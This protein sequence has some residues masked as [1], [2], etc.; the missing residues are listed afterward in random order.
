MAF[1]DE[2]EC[3]IMADR[4]P[5]TLWLKPADF[6][7]LVAYVAML[8]VFVP[9]H[10]PWEDEAQAWLL[11]RDLSLYSLLFKALRREGHPALWYLILWV[12]TR[13][14]LSYTLFNWLSAAIATL[15][16]Y[17]LLRLS[18]FPFYLRALLPFTFFLGYQYSVVARSYVLFP[19]L[20]FLVAHVYREQPPRPLLMAVLLAL[21][22]NVSVHGTIVA[23]VF[24]ALYVWK[25]KQTGDDP[26]NRF[27]PPR[28]IKLAAAIFTSSILFVAICLWPTEGALP[29]VGPTLN[30]IFDSLSVRKSIAVSPQTAEAT[31]VPQAGPLAV[32]ATSKTASPIPGKA[33]MASVVP[34]LSFAFA[35]SRLLALLYE[36]V[37][38]L[39]LWRSGQMKLAL[40]A[41]ALCLFLIF[42]YAAPWHL[43][44]LWI[45]SLMVLWAAWDSSIPPDV[46]AL[47]NAVAAFLALLCLLQLPWTFN[48][49]RFDARNATSPGKATAAYLKSLPSGRRIAGFGMSVGVQPYFPHNVFFNRPDT[50]ASFAADPS[51]LSIPQAIALRPDIIVADANQAP[52]IDVSGYRPIQVFCGSLYLPNSVPQPS[53]L[54]VYEPSVP[55]PPNQREP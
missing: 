26:A 27:P 42:V 1:D 25:L 18:P 29:R 2:L 51:V 30:K 35:T 45:T 23:I 46:P 10:E 22:A 43:G 24:A 9:F 39:Y 17:V 5:A 47:Q 3:C 14:H 11:S 40:P 50:F 28:D 48:A 38:L 37:L 7:V 6:G 19:V 31:S 13:L 54:S 33:R 36:G 12:A 16:I 34:V 15:G 52:A 21:L 4:R 20:G 53:C 41:A 44:L 8:C 55:V 49:F 32:T